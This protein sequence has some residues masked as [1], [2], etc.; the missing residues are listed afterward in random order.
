MQLCC[1][2]SVALRFQ[3]QKSFSWKLGHVPL[4]FCSFTH[5]TVGKSQSELCWFP[6]EVVVFEACLAT[7]CTTCACTDGCIQWDL[8]QRKVMLDHVESEQVFRWVLSTELHLIYLLSLQSHAFKQPAT[9][10][11][12]WGSFPSSPEKT[13]PK[14]TI[15]NDHLKVSSKFATCLHLT[16]PLATLPPTPSHP[17]SRIF[18]WTWYC[19]L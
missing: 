2:V 14:C 13:G 12:T 9:G 19:S 6:D 11:L 16:F 17:T 10:N 4:S 7:S 15:P 5:I 18:I 1:T 3:E 8:D